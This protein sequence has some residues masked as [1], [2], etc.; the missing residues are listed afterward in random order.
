ME[1]S[2]KSLIALVL[3]TIPIFTLLNRNKCGDKTVEARRFAS[4][5]KVLQSVENQWM[6]SSKNYTRLIIANVSVASQQ[7]G[8]KSGKNLNS[9]YCAML[10]VIDSAHTWLILNKLTFC[11][12][13]FFA[14]ART[15]IS[16]GQ[17]WPHHKTPVIQVKKPQKSLLILFYIY[18]V[19]Q[20]KTGYSV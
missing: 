7:V 12:S 1:S 2:P 8:I 15:Y 18:V 19:L 5:T 9:M 14:T 17:I 4:C 11:S 16:L 10:P 20:N 3:F 6:P 13:W